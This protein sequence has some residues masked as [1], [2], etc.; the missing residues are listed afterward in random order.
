MAKSLVGPVVR[1]PHPLDLDDADWYA[2]Q[3][4][5][6]EIVAPPQTHSP[7][8]VGVLE[9]EVQASKNPRR[10]LRAREAT[11]LRGQGALDAITGW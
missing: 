9:S 10:L 7:A 2:L 1:T 3:G 11:A 8:G 4:Q 5:N 6:P